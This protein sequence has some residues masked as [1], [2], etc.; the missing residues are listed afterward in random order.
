[1]ELIAYTST[2]FNVPLYVDI[3]SF[4]IDTLLLDIGND[5]DVILGTPWLARIGIITWNF[6]SMAMQFHRNGCNINFF[7]ISNP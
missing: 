4:C 3:E 1:M 6:E 5:I 7:G 2:F